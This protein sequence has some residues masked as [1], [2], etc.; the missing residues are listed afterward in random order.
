MSA[1]QRLLTFLAQTFPREEGK[2]ITPS[3]PLLD[4]GLIDSVGIFELVAF[5]ERDFGVNV[6]D[7]EIVPE[8]FET[9][10]HIARFV[11]RKQQARSTAS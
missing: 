10:A 9:V 6:Q 4:E 11:E 3:D 2:A 1:E 5:I 8:N 7:E